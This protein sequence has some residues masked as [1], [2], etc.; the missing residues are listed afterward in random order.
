MSQNVEII[1]TD[2][3]TLAL[4]HYAQAIKHGGTIYVSGQCFKLNYE[5]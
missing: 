2:K 3:A 5:F 4:G 1:E